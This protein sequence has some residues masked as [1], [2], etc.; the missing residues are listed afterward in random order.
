MK[1]SKREFAD[2]DQ[3]ELGLIVECHESIYFMNNIF[4]F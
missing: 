2:R 3:N 4:N 1:D